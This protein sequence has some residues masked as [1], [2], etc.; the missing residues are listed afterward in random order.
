MMSLTPLSST[1]AARRQRA[2]RQLEEAAARRAAEE[3]DE[4]RVEARRRQARERWQRV[5]GHARMIARANIQAAQR[6]LR[7]MAVDRG[8]SEGLQAAAERF[9]TRH[10]AF[11][12]RAETL[13]AQL[14]PSIS[15]LWRATGAFRSA[16]WDVTTN[17]LVL[18]S[19][20]AEEVAARRAVAKR[21]KQE[22]KRTIDVWA[23]RAL[24]ADAKGLY[25][26]DGVLLKRFANDWKRALRIGIIKFISQFDDDAEGDM[27]G[28]GIPD[29]VQEV[30]H[31]LFDHR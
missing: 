9:D 27:D 22:K 21:R 11:Q 15:G 30:A 31:V 5:R 8:Y 7:Q 26:D 25:D 23:P 29:E 28:D 14:D 19:A 24:W 13:A 18:P 17:R 10:A 16:V 20:V 2:Q 1:L 4:A 6:T 12:S 3:S